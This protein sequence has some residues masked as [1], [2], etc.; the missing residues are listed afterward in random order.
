M[1]EDATAILKSGTFNQNA[2]PDTG[3]DKPIGGKGVDSF[4]YEGIFNGDPTKVGKNNFL[5]K[6]FDAFKGIDISQSSLPKNIIGGS[7][8]DKKAF[9]V[10][11]N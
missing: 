1:A 9:N 7:Q 5:N 2:L 11:I 8:Q 3:L 6:N 4:G 10:K